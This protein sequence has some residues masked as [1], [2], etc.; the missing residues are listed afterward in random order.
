MQIRYNGVCSGLAEIKSSRWDTTSISMFSGE[1]RE[2]HFAMK[3]TMSLAAFL[4]LLFVLSIHADE[5]RVEISADTSE[6]VENIL[7]DFYNKYSLPGGISMAISYRE[8][9][10]YAG[11]IG[12]ADKEHKIPLTPEH[13]MRIASLS[14]PITSIAV[15][16]LVEEKKLNLNDEVFGSTGIFGGEYGVPVYE[17]CPVKIT[18]KQLLEHTAGGWGNSRRDP[19]FSIRNAAG[20]EFI[21]TVIKEYPLENSPGTK[22]D[23]SNFGYC[24]LGRVIEKKSGM[25]YENYV[26]KHVLTPCGISGMRIGGKTSEP[27]EV[28][29]IDSSGQNPYLLSPAHMDAHGGWVAN[30]IELLKLL[31]RVDG[32]SNVPDILESETIK[33]MTTPSEQNDGYAL[34]WSVNRSNNWW[35]TGSLPGTATEMARSSAGYNWVIL[36]NFRPSAAP[37]FFGDLDRLFWTIKETVQE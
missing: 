14:K 2:H 13:R 29:Y 21:R 9:L 12:Y 22:Y 7:R 24:V 27:D 10:V 5:V 8:K 3:K 1:I 15:M 23:Y 17:N 11:A 34:G 16:K 25:T 36:V 4:C 19:M 35:H 33:T 6:T 31:V 18:V 20:D 28:E 26:K 30:P 37:D 32:F